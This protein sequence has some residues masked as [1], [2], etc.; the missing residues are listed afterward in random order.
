[1]LDRLDIHIEVP[2][3]DF[4]KLSSKVQGESSEEIR[5]RVNKVRK[6]QQERLRGTGVSCNAKMDAALTKEFCRP[7]K[8]AMILLE[9]VFDRLDFSARAYDKILRVSRTI[10]D[11]SESD[12]IEAEHIAQAVQFRSLDRKFWGK[13]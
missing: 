12:D 5:K 8:E 3:V 6:I 13:R 2:P 9:E 4:E 1:M 10:A 11:M 7:T